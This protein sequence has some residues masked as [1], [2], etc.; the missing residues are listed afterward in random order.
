MQVFFLLATRQFRRFSGK[1]VKLP[2]PI[3]SKQNPK[4]LFN[5]AAEVNQLMI[6][7][8]ITRIIGAHTL[9]IN[10]YKALNFNL[11]LKKNLMM[12]I[13]LDNLQLKDGTTVTIAK[14][15]QECLAG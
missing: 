11:W 13:K 10:K 12:K 14:S 8:V 5:K 1:G 6:S 3:V 4:A 9:L 7:T 2:I 15:N